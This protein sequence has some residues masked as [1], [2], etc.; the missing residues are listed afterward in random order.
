MMLAN[1][2]LPK[3]RVTLARVVNKSLGR[4]DEISE[5]AKK[6]AAEDAAKEPRERLNISN[7]L[8]RAKSGVRLEAESFASAVSLLKDP[9]Q[10]QKLTTEHT[11]DL[12]ALD[13]IADGS[14][15]TPEDMVEMGI[16]NEESK[17]GMSVLQN[18]NATNEIT[19][20]DVEDVALFIR[21]VRKDGS[22]V[23]P[24]D[25]LVVIREARK[26]AGANPLEALAKLTTQNTAD[27]TGLGPVLDGVK[28]TPEQL[29]GMGVVDEEAKKGMSVLEGI[30]ATNDIGEQDVG[31]VMSLLRSVRKDG[32]VVT[33]NDALVVIREAM[34][35]AG[36]PSTN[37]LFATKTSGTASND[38]S[39]ISEVATAAAQVV[40]HQRSRNI[41]PLMA[42]DAPQRAAWN[43]SQT[44]LVVTAVMAFSGGNAMA[45]VNGEMVHTGDVVSVTSEGQA[46]Q[47]RL[48]ALSARG[49]IWEPVVGRQNEIGSALIRWQ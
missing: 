13:L 24:N 15:L 23:T 2:V 36:R 31:K 45:I 18:V 4:L 26:R 12:K 7:L 49:V 3:D 33:T 9:Q 1:K 10:L 35:R 43:R 32:S 30:R 21:S 34:K 25:A 28:L 17:K 14:V 37:E 48:A 42:L 22:Q 19:E 27:L 16:V 8:M 38:V 20:Q 39:S 40:I 46:F 5:Q 47:W 44:G 6:Q 29:A 11:E 41:D